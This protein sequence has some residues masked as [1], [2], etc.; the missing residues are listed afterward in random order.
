MNARCFF[1]ALTLGVSAWSAPIDLAG[2]SQI[3]FGAYTFTQNAGGPVATFAGGQLAAVGET[4]LAGVPI[5]G[6]PGLGLRGAQVAGSNLVAT[7]VQTWAAANPNFLAANAGAG[8][9]GVNDPGFGGGAAV[10]AAYP[11]YIGGSFFLFDPLGNDATGSV[12]DLSADGTWT[13]NLGVP[14]SGWAGA[15]LAYRGTFGNQPNA[16]VAASLTGTINGVP[17]T[18][19]VLAGSSIAGQPVSLG[20]GAFG[21]NYFNCGLL[22]CNDFVAWGVSLTG[23]VTIPNGGTFSA[24]GTLSVI[25]D[26]PASIILISLDDPNFLNPY[27]GPLPTLGANMQTPETSTGLLFAVPGLVWIALR[28]RVVQFRK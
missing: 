4:D 13:N 27:S 11:F 6:S 23:F 20:G 22:F 8:A 16:V 21:L 9:N 3:T 1:A 5:G 14:V 7:G 2:S 10:V 17:W 12:L 28:R 24:A 26:P 15:F 25:A 18:P 19:I